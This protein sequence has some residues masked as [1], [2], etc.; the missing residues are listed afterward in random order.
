MY[1]WR[2]VD[3]EGEVLDI[4]AQSDA[5]DMRRY[6]ALMMKC[7]P[8]SRSSF[9][10]QFDQRFHPDSTTNGRPVEAHERVPEVCRAVPMRGGTPLTICAKSRIFPENAMAPWRTERSSYLCPWLSIAVKI[11]NKYSY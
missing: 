7:C 10:R 8:R 11:I 4:L 9:V 3:G 5:T 1:L 2:A 6:F